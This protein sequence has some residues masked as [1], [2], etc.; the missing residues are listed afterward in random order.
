MARPPSTD[1][2]ETFLREVDEDL[3]RDQVRDFFV[4]NRV[5]LIA[6]VVLFLGAS[7]GWLWWQNRQVEQSGT[8]VEE[9]ARIYRD[10]ATGNF[11]KAP[12]ELKPLAE[13]SSEGI[14]ASALFTAAAI[15]LQKGDQKAALA[16]YQTLAANGDLPSPY[17]E[18]ALIRQTTLEFDQVK[19]DA[20][21]E[22]MK[23]LAV[24]GEPWFG[25]AAELTA[26]AL[27]KQSKKAEAGKLFAAIARDKTAPESLRA[28]S[29]QM[30]SSLG[31]DA[32][33]A[34]PATAQ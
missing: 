16:K 12:A 22:Q 13:S 27:I 23:P 1:V 10:F 33:D 11:D 31:V 15:D 29:V 21:I 28:R 14:S 25:S 7:G 20:V 19:P 5:L 18:L 32:S 8:Q 2:N 9:L 3:R 30:A 6:A 17:R 24:P 26:L 4:N 34:M